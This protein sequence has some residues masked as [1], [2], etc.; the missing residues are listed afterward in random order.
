MESEAHLFK[1]WYV[2]EKPESC[3]LPKTI[4]DINLF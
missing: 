3:D 4:K 1:K 2:D